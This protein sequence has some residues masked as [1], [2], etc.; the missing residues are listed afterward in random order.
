MKILIVGAGSIAREYLKVCLAQ[1]HD[2]VV[3]GYGEVNVDLARDINPSCEF[4][5]GGLENYLKKHERNLPDTAIVSTPIETLYGHVRLLLNL[6]CSR[7]L[8][9]K[10]LVFT[11]QEANELAILAK[12]NNSNVFIAFNR[13]FYSSVRKA[14]SIIES[15]GGLSSMFFD[16]TEAI[17][18]I[19]KQKYDHRTLR[20]FGIAN[21]SHVLDTAFFLAGMPRNMYASAEGSLP[22]HPDG[23][24]FTGNGVTVKNVMFSYHANWSSAGRWSIQLMTPRRKLILCPMEKLQMQELGS[25]EISYV[26]IHDNLDIEFKPGFYRQVEAFLNDDKSSLL[27][28]NHLG[29]LIRQMRIVFNY[30]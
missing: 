20:N 23:S 14:M 21:S 12:Q 28:I 17:H 8:V 3:V 9:E 25:F 10:P 11:E 15:D 29:I 5:I 19:S 2:P 6:G 27:D 24:V 30:C 22:W 26:D 13:R 16:F 18:R 4:H 7:I 1:G